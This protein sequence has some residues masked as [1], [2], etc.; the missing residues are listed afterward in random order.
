MA[1]SAGDL[2]EEMDTDPE[3]NAD[4][5]MQ[6]ESSDSDS[7]VNEDTEEEKHILELEDKIKGNPFHYDSHMEFIGYLRKTGNLDKLREAREAMAKI[8]PLTPELW[9]DWIKDESKL[10]ES[11]EDKER[12][13]QL[14]ER[15]VKD[16]LSVAL[17]LEY[18]QFSIGLMGSEGGLDRVRSV[19]ERA[20]TGAGLHVSQ[21]ALLWEAY[22]EFEAVLLA[23]MQPSAEE[24]GSSSDQRDLFVSQRNRVYNLYKRQLS[25]PLFGMEKTYE[26]LREWSEAA[27]EPSVEQQYKKA[28]LRLDKIQKYETDLLGG[29]GTPAL[30]TY[31]SYLDF[32]EAQGDPTRVQSLYERAISDHCLVPEL[33]ER[34]MAYLDTKL[35]V[36]AVS[37]PCHE[38]SVR[39]CPWSSSLWVSH[40]KALERSRS[41][42]QKLTEAMEQALGAGFGQGQDY[43]KLWLTFLDY[44]RRRVDWSQGDS[45]EA[46]RDLRRAFEKAVEHLVQYQEETDLC[47]PILKYWAKVEAKFCDNLPKAR[48]LWNEVTHQGR[49]T[50]A[51][52]WLDF[53]NFE[54]AFGD[55]KHLRKTLMRGMYAAVDWPE[56]LGDML[57]NFEREEGTLETLDVA[58]E[59]YDAHI[60]RVLEKREKVAQKE[61]QKEAEQQEQLKSTRAEKKAERKA[62]KKAERKAEKLRQDQKAQEAHEGDQ[63]SHK[64]KVF[65]RKAPTAQGEELKTD[66]DGFKV[67]TLPDTNDVEGGTDGPPTKKSKGEEKEGAV[68]GE[69][70]EPDPLR[71][72]RTVFLSN[73]AYDVQDDQLTEIFKEVGTIEELRLVRDYKGR[74]KGFGYLVF[75]DQ[76][77]VDAALAKDRTPVAG[78]PVFV[79]RCN[80]RTQFKFQ[81][82]LEKN[83]LF[84]RGIPFSMDE[85]GLE[86]IFGK[87]GDLKQIRIVT[88]RNGHSK[89]IAYVEFTNETSATVALVQT[90]GMQLGK[91][92]LQVAISN[93]P[94]R[95]PRNQN[96]Q[97]SHGGPRPVPVAS[98]GGGPKETGLRG[99]SRTQVSLMPRAL[100]RPQPQKPQPQVKGETVPKDALPE[101]K[102]LSNADFRNLLLKK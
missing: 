39:N 66:S 25:V 35:K 45:S 37:L 99:R 91:H 44:L 57:L 42:H 34:Y 61:A 56:T 13:I 93:P 46:L 12:V 74:S 3:N 10:C 97:D 7:D 89:G 83:K 55:D 95:G 94:S 11:D 19:F 23:T 72:I 47:S 80:E 26:E 85:K 86:E 81:T 84:V 54:R 71:D 32:E 48:E 102:G 62:E 52:T 49:A 27:I 50:D 21:G 73:L 40:L 67:P 31:L 65:K 41:P 100:Q 90:D 88:Y 76:R 28:K 101:T 22:R 5:P 43:Q 58:T 51:Q 64:P 69:T 2:T 24:G 63:A 92:T 1:G 9:L 87:Y 98:L 15:A 96:P 77:D 53:A 78:R 33:W 68:H 75:A 14:F 38:R 30:S 4:E 17:W 16:Y 79:S 36:D 29:E 82:G 8:F 70:V 20:I 18:A 60:R 59:K 6:D